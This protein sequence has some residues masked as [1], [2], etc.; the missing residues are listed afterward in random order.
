MIGLSKRWAAHTSNVQGCCGG[1]A[2][3]LAGWQVVPAWRACGGLSRLK[4]TLPAQATTLPA[5]WYTSPSL[6][7]LERTRVF[8]ASWQLAGAADAVA[9]PGAYFTGTLPP[10]RFIVARSDDGI[11]RAFHNVRF[12][13]ARHTWVWH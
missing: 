8:G 3:H 13:S 9:A 5:S 7:P 10:W 6:L 11:L 2:A 12:A 1:A 4:L